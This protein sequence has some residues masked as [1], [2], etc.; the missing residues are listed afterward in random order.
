MGEFLVFFWS[1]RS[2]EALDELGVERF[3]PSIKALHVGAAND[4]LGD[5]LPV[6]AAVLLDSGSEH[7]VFFLSPVALHELWVEHIVPSV[8]A[9]HI[10][11]TWHAHGNLLPLL[12]PVHL[13]GVPE[14]VVLLLAPPSLVILGVGGHRLLGDHS[15]LT[16]GKLDLSGAPLAVSVGL[17]D[18]SAAFKV[19]HLLLL[20]FGRLDSLLS[21]HTLA[22]DHVAVFEHVLVLASHDVVLMSIVEKLFVVFEALVLLL[23]EHLIC[24]VSQALLFVLAGVVAEARLAG[25]GVGVLPETWRRDVVDCVFDMGRWGKVGRWS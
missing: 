1:P 4:A 5:L 2:L 16:A 18:S 17:G 23:V 6:L 14:L 11:T 12:V 13:D 8:A 10:R 24:L 15:V 19:S 7:I 3:V 20:V 22:A 25:A 21:D 9:L